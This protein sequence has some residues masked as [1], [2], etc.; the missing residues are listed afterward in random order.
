[1]KKSRALGICSMLTIFFALV[2]LLDLFPANPGGSVYRGTW[3]QAHAQ[4]VVRVPGVTQVPGV[5]PAPGVEP[6]PEVEPS[7]G[8]APAPGLAPATQGVS[9]APGVVSAPNVVSSPGV[10]SAPSVVTVP[11][12]VAAP[13]VLHLTPQQQSWRQRI[14][15]WFSSQYNQIHQ[16]L[17]SWLQPVSSGIQWVKNNPWK[18]LAIAV[19]VVVAAVLL[20]KLGVVAAIGGLIKGAVLAIK[21]SWVGKSFSAVVFWLKKSWLAKKIIHIGNLISGA[22]NFLWAKVL[23]KIFGKAWGK[24]IFKKWTFLADIPKTILGYILKKLALLK[25]VGWALKFKEALENIFK[26]FGWLRAAMITLLSLPKRLY[27]YLR[28]YFSPST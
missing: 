21:T 25:S 28:G 27:Q 26:V 10:I 13:P 5:A 2:V 3:S 1:M 18:S 19:G 16:T 23:T 14:S 24:W 11:G 15:G 12:V 6:A 7:P 22:I 17:S 8:V 9:P 4:S 20:V